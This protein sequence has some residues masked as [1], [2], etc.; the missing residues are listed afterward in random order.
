MLFAKICEVKELQKNV[1][2]Q[3]VLDDGKQ[4]S[5]TLA[6]SST[7]KTLRG[8][9]GGKYK[10][11]D[12]FDTARRMNLPRNAVGGAGLAAKINTQEK[13]LDYDAMNQTDRVAEME[14]TER[15]M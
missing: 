3:I 11:N 8:H 6:Q 4:I 15:L 14:R 2:R 5:Y 13:E 10:E 7:E 9:T 12:I 1:H